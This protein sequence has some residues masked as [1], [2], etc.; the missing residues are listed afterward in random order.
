MIVLCAQA[1]ANLWRRN[2]FSLVNQIHNYFSPLCRTQMFDKDI[3]M[4]QV[5]LRLTKIMTFKLEIQVGLCYEY[6]KSDEQ[7]LCVKN[8]WTIN[9]WNTRDNGWYSRGMN[10]YLTITFC[11]CFF[12]FFC[13]I[14]AFLYKLK[15]LIGKKSF[16]HSVNWRFRS[17][18]FV[19]IQF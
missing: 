4:L 7:E 14:T 3:L 17:P 15:A 13:K 8:T 11:C 5:R 12:F 18:V 6:A 1:G 10:F 19:A 2:G 16:F 9:L